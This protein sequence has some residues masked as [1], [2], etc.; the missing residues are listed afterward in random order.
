MQDGMDAQCLF[1]LFGET[2]AVI[3][4]AE[5]Q[6]TRLSLELLNVAF[7]GFGETMEHREDAHG[8]VAVQTPNIG[9]GTLG[10]S[11]FLHG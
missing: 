4:D 5:A 11:D 6:L 3:A 7:A 1:W 2:D 9:A 10:P 8:S